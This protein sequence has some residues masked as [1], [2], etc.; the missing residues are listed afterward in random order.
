MGIPRGWGNKRREA[1][2]ESHQRWDRIE[3]RLRMSQDV[4]ADKDGC[5]G[6]SRVRTLQRGEVASVAGR[7]R[8]SL[9]CSE[10]IF[11]PALDR[12]SLQ[13]PTQALKGGRASGVQKVKG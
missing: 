8:I 10:Q 3:D 4:L 2:R 13:Q 9:L 7:S 12:I 6:S 11:R 5:E 1:V